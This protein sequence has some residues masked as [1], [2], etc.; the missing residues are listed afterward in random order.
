VK[1][2]SVSTR[3]IYTEN[4]RQ[5]AASDTYVLRGD[6][7]GEIYEPTYDFV[8]HSLGLMCDLFLDLL[9]MVFV[10]YLYLIHLIK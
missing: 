5:A 10:I 4:L 7:A 3:D 8:Y 2:F 1:V 6:P 9:F